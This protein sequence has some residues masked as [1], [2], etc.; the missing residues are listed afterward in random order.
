MADIEQ[1]KH[2][3]KEA[4]AAS[5]EERR[6][7]EASLSAKSSELHALQTNIEDWIKALE[8]EKAN[9]H[10]SAVEH[11]AE[12]F[13]ETYRLELNDQIIDLGACKVMVRPEE[14]YLDTERTL[15]FSTSDEDDVKEII[16][17]EGRY[18]FSD[19]QF[20]HKRH[21]SQYDIFTEEEFYKLIYGWVRL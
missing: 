13:N 21:L 20:G 12:K 1:L 15:L 17:S 16:E 10:Y 9:I 4:V 8:L 11:T 14:N 18:Y 5:Q 3:I 19:L 2:R 7:Y 6:E